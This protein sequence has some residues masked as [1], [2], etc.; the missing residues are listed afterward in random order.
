MRILHALRITAMLLLAAPLAALAQDET[1]LHARTRAFLRAVEED[2]I[3]AVAAYFPRRGDWTWIQTT[4]GRGYPRQ[5]GTWRFPAEHTLIAIRGGAPVCE[6]FKQAGGEFGPMYGT[7]ADALREHGTA[8]RQLR[9]TRFAP[10]AAARRPDTYIEWK[11][12][13][14]RW[15]IAAVADEVIWYTPAP[16]PARPL[17]PATR[18]EVPPHRPGVFAATEGYA[19]GEPWF[20]QHAPIEFDGLRYLTEGHL[21]LTIPDEHLARIGSL[22]KVGIYAEAATTGTHPVIYIPLRPGGVYQPF[23]TS[24]PFRCYEP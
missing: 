22:G 7:L 6:S 10:R 4:H 9:G 19:A 24:G 11:R 20:E 8:W 5:V 23:R 1:T 12:E 13:E 2:S 3:E 16:A 15:V 17:A 18:R 14:G 21:P